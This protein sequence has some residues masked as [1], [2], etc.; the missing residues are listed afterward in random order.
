MNAT[1]A[2]AGMLSAGADA[3]SRVASAQIAA[4]AANANTAAAL[5][6]ERA[7]L[8]GGPR[9]QHVVDQQDVV[10]R[11]QCVSVDFYAVGSVFQRVVDPKSLTWKL[12]SLA[13]RN[14]TQTHVTGKG[15]AKDEATCFDSS[16]RGKPAVC[17][18]CCTGIK[19]K[20]HCVVV[21][22]YRGEILEHNPWGRIVRN[23]DDE[24]FSP[25]LSGCHRCERGRL[26]RC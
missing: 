6:G 7:G 3:N 4:N 18:V 24:R 14:K 2:L 11:A 19:N 15:C 21:G 12:A 1:S 13:N 9:R 17:E 10:T 20:C 25:L 22:E 5:Q 16:N 8:D 23:L 26:T